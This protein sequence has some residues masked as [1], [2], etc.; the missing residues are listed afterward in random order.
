MILSQSWFKNEPIII[1]I[2]YT[3]FSGYIY[4]FKK[5]ILDML[6]D[7]CMCMVSFRFFYE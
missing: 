7:F 6:A 2:I 5:G 3:I 1:W 4:N